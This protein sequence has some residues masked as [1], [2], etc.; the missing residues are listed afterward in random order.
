MTN[1]TLEI[2]IG[3]YIDDE[4]TNGEQYVLD[5][6]LKNNPKA[7]ELLAQLQGMHKYS[8]SAVLSGIVEQ[9]KTT[10]EIFE[11][12][13]QR[14]DYESK[15]IS[16]PRTRIRFASGVAV[17]LIIGLIIQF[18]LILSS[19]QQNNSRPQRTIAQQTNSLQNPQ[20]TNQQ[21]LPYNNGN[22]IRNVDWY[23]F[24]DEDGS[25]WL[26]EGLQ[27]NIIRSAAYEEGL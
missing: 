14:A 25:Q 4:I 6:E 18:G 13:W 2:I 8:R 17:G 10:E 23:S 9:G 22:V 21:Q 5:A 3:K 7:K 19:R 1:E 16:K 11:Q 20:I 24:T 26:I 15:H 27:E 12:A